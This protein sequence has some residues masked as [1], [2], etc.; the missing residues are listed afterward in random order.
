MILVP[1]S[2]YLQNLGPLCSILWHIHRVA[3][4]AENRAVVIDIQHF[5]F[6]CDSTAES[7]AASV[8]GYHLQSIF[9]PCLP[10]Q[11]SRGGQGSCA[12]VE[13]EISIRVPSWTEEERI[14]FF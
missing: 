6:H 8:R 13:V 11:A 1:I 12:G 5:D 7:W 2:T 14:F 9:S 4:A 10:V 3:T